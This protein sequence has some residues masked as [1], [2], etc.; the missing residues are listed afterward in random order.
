[1][2]VDK[3]IVVAA[4]LVC[5]IFFVGIII[6]ALIGRVESL[7]ENRY[8]RDFIQKKAMYDLIET[9]LKEDYIKIEGKCEFHDLEI[10]SKRGTVKTN[11]F[12]VC[13]YNIEGGKPQK[14]TEIIYKDD[15]YPIWTKNTLWS[16][17]II[18]R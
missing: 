8:V 14:I 10:D 7:I 9:A 12:V 18:K 3:I 4:T 15:P 16:P 17:W 1:M 5:I 13:E 6:S 2:E 11:G